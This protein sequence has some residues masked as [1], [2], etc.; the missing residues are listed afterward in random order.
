MGYGT[1]LERAIAELDRCEDIKVERQ[2]AD[3]D[4]TP[5]RLA[6]LADAD[7][8]LDRIAVHWRTRLEDVLRPYYFAADEYHAD[9]ITADGRVRGEF[10]LGNI[11]GCLVDGHLP[12]TDEGLGPDERRVLP[13]LRIFDQAPFGGAGQVTGLRVLPRGGGVE[14]WY[15]VLTRTELHRLNLDYGTYLEALLITKG[16]WGWQ[17]LFAD[18]DLTERRYHD[19]AS[20]LAAM[21][22]ALPVLF[23][24]HDYEPLRARWRERL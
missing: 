21:F 10:C 16:A 19:A 13:E 18:V 1:R 4:L 14:I 17:Y 2:P 23:P 7:L 8:A 9:W 3:P 24:D 20:N 5:E 15:Y 6:L 22:E 12:L 11:H